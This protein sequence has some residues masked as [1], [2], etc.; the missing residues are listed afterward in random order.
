MKKRMFLSTILMT[1]VLLLAVTT[2]T[3]AWYQAQAASA[4]KRSDE[5][6]VNT[7]DNGYA[8]G[9]ILFTVDVAAVS[10]KLALSDNNGDTWYY[11]GS[12]K[13]KDTTNPTDMAEVT[14]TVTA[15]KADPTNLASLDEL[16]AAYTLGKDLVVSSENAQVRLSATSADVYKTTSTNSLTLS[17]LQS[18]QFTSANSYTLEFTFWV[19]IAGQESVENPLSFEIAGTISGLE[20]APQ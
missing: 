3:F 10:E 11:V 9:G 6:A 17:T 2:A 7:A 12:S 16:L 1:L 19:S 20:E 13:V 5:V 8:A 15:A 18:A 14:V 4:Q